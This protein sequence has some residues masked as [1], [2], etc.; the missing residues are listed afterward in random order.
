MVK[1]RTRLVGYA[2]SIEE[3]RRECKISFREPH[4]EE[5]LDVLVIF[6]TF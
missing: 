3:A 4:T 1:S 2:A 6:V 5:Y